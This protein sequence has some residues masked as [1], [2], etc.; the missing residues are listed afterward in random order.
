MELPTR[1]WNADVVLETSDASIITK[2]KGQ[3]DRIE[4]IQNSYI[5]MII[6]VWRFKNGTKFHW[7]IIGQRNHLAT[8]VK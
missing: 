8:Y 5:D 7:P 2:R 1:N 3:K 4:N 6:K